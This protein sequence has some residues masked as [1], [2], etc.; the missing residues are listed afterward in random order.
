MQTTIN[1]PAIA[2]GFQ[3]LQ[4][5]FFPN[6][7]AVI[8]ADLR[9]REGLNIDADTRYRDASTANIAQ[10]TSDLAY[11]AAELQKLVDTMAGADLTNPATRAALAA[12]GLG[13]GTDP[14]ALAGMSAYANPKFAAPE[15]LATIFI[16]TGAADNYGQTQPG[17][18]EGLQNNLDQ[19]GVQGQN[20]LNELDW[21]AANPGARVSGSG[22]PGG[23]TPLD[24]SP[25]D[26]AN[27]QALTME[28]IAQVAG[29]TSETLNVDGT[30][31]N[32][33]NGLV[34]KYYQ[35]S[36]NAQLAISQALADMPMQTEIVDPS[37]WPLSTMQMNVTQAPAPSSVEPGS[38]ATLAD[39]SKVQWDG[40]AWVPLK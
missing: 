1:N 17:Y 26:A 33:L 29:V 25:M 32:A 4:S 2:Q 37:R 35:Q 20:R 27:L 36:R 16:G 8:E 34:S 3:A 14:S 30:Y 5:A 23:G 9:R 10:Q 31:L 28:T 7:N 18:R 12:A 11:K 6:P 38:T 24:V 39:G 22:V 15:D 13:S 19:L 21:F 40:Q